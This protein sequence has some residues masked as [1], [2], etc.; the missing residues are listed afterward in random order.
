MQII[1]SPAKLMSFINQREEPDATKPLF[2]GKTKE[3]VRIC[4]QLPEEEIASTMNIN[5]KMAREVYE[6]FQT[7][8]FR[9]TPKRAAAMAYNGIAYKGLHACDFSKEDFDFAQQHL[10]I[11]SGLYGIIRP[12]DEVRPYRLEMKRKIVPRGYNT[13]YDFWQEALNAYLSKKLRR[14]DK[15]I[16]NVASNEYAKAIQKS[17]LPKGTRF[18]DIQFL[19]QENGDLKQIVVHSK[20]AR[21]LMARFI[22]KNKLTDAEEA[23]GFD[24]EGYFFY[25]ALSKEDSWVFIR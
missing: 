11:I 9:N 10:N 16:I 6:Y 3:L 22:I 14:D 21:G 24:Y 1:L 4:Q 15:T 7:F 18:I 19:Q 20:K 17:K 12:L 5:A 2:P 25:P 23:K 13:L 8:T